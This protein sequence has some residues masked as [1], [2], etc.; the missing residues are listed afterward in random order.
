MF[1]LNTPNMDR[2]GGEPENIQSNR[3]TTSCTTTRHRRTT[4][5]KIVQLL[6]YNWSRAI[7]IEPG[8]KVCITYQP[9]IPV[10]SFTSI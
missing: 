3:W 10:T 5:T 8:V 1:T 6:P 7:F 2:E 4:I 9:K